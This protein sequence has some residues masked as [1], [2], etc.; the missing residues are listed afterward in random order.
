MDGSATEGTL[1]QVVEV[2]VVGAGLAGLTAARDLVRAGLSV[3]VLEATN[4]V[5]GRVVGADIGDGETIE[6]GGQWLGPTQDHVLAMVEDLGLST[7]PTHITG[8]HTFHRGG[9]TSHWDAAIGPIPPIKPAALAQVQAV[10]AGIQELAAQIDP[11]APWAASKAAEWDAT[12]FSDWLYAR[13]G[14]PDARMLADYVIRGTN[15][16]EPKDVSLLHMVRYVAAAGNAQNPGSLLRVIVTAN[17]AS[18]FRV[19]GGSQR[20]PQLLAEELGDVVRLSAPVKQ[21]RQ[22]AEGVLVRAGASQ[23]RAQRVIIAVPLAAVRRIAFDP[24]LPAERDAVSEQ[25]LPGAQ[26]KVNVVYERPFWRAE[27]LTGYVCSDTWPVQNVWDNTPESSRPGVLLCFVKGSAAT[28]LDG[29]GEDEIRTKVLDNLQLF[30]GAAAA[31]PRQVL[32]HRWHTQPYVW[33]CPGSLAPTGA[34]AAFGPAMREPTGRFHWAGTETATYWPGFMDGAI[35][36]GH[37]AALEVAAL[38]AVTS[39]S[40]RS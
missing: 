9:V 25:L 21:I 6:M 16:I 32:I 38:S 12:R 15:A 28:D 36:S 23:V 1:D 11:S 39:S 24:P 33:G 18:Q 19:V 8:L 4:R 34:I 10:I 13:A 14:E 40:T 37:R 20:I 26:I 31:D 3:C 35:G 2:A 22:D 30:F 7:H 17:G 29:A 5:G 27:G